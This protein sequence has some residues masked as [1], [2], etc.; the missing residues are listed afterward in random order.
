MN[1]LLSEYISRSF[2]FGA[3]GRLL[4]NAM[5]SRIRGVKPNTP[6]ISPDPPMEKTKYVRLLGSMT[7]IRICAGATVLGAR[8][9]ERHARRSV[10]L[11]LLLSLCLLAGASV[12]TAADSQ[13]ILR[14]I[15]TWNGSQAAHGDITTVRDSNYLKVTAQAVSDGAL[16]A[17]MEIWSR[18]QSTFGA[19]SFEPLRYRFHLKSNILTNEV[20]DLTFHQKTGLV[21]VDKWKGDEREKH[22]ERR[23]QAYDPIA[24][25]FLL[26]YNRDLSK[27]QY[28]DVYDGKD[29]AR[30]YVRPCSSARGPLRLKCGM[31]DAVGID[32]ELVKLGREKQKI[33]N[34]RLWLSN[35]H[36]RIPLLLTSSHML[37]SIRFE[38]VQVQR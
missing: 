6:A 26:R 11:A 20:V 35:D 32:L 17:I 34:G 1:N 38:L 25:A 36:D 30:I 9:V 12:A 23:D 19:K 37:G 2:P 31:F 8:Q 16:R 24:A 10:V 22:K 27:P 13:E 14:Y 4:P 28:V 15:V 7:L 29:R 18:V 3:N 5:P 33:G 21:S